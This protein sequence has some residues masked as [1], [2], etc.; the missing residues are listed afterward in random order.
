MTSRFLTPLQ[1]PSRAP[2]GGDPLFDLHREMNR[3]FDDFL[4]AGAMAGP[5]QLM[6]APRLE[7]REDP[8]EIRLCAE[9]PGVRPEDVDLRM[10][11][12]LLILRG[13]KRQETQRQQ[14]DCH[15]MER[16]YGRFQRSLQLPY[17]PDPGQVHAH[18]ENGVLTVHVPKQP[19]QERSRRIE[20]QAQGPQEA[21]QGQ[22]NAPGTGAGSDAPAADGASRSHH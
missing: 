16:S 3:L 8:H 12:N 1:P 14:E 5:S 11:G 22:I 6:A 10:E 4:G 21:Q 9:L 7:V 13:E 20:I 18:F 19:E 15:L 17:A 2:A